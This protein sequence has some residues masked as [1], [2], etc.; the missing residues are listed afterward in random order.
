MKEVCIISLSSDGYEKRLEVNDSEI[1]LEESKDLGFGCTVT[2]RGSPITPSVHVTI[3]GEDRT[4]LFSATNETHLVAQ[5]SPLSIFQSEVKL[6]MH[7]RKPNVN[8]N[9]KIM[10]CTAV[11]SG[12]DPVTTSALLV[13][14]CKLDR[15]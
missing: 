8:F 3:A 11:V 15:S 6:T 14:R 7:T 13:V 4:G 12:F 1:F 5:D 9:G 2:L 10:K